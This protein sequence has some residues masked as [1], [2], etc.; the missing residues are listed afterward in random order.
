MVL[1]LK[2]AWPKGNAKLMGLADDTRMGKLKEMIQEHSGISPPCQSILEGYPLKPLLGTDMSLLTDLGVRSGAALTVKVVEAPA[3]PELQQP[4]PTAATNG[5]GT[6]GGGAS[7]IGMLLDMGFAPDLAARA[8]QL[9]GGDAAAAVELCMSGALEGVAAMPAPAP[10]APR[11]LP[12][13]TFVRR[14]I[15]AD[16]SCLFNAVGFCLHRSRRRGGELRAVIA[17]A[18]QAAPDVFTAAILG[19]EAGEY[20][21]WIQD[22][23]KWGGEIELFVLSR[24]FRTEICAVDVQTGIAYTYGEGEGYRERMF[25]LYDGIHY[26]ALSEAFNPTAD[27]SRD[28][29]VFPIGAEADRRLAAAK[30]IAKGLREKKLFV[31]LGGCDLK[32]LVCLEGLRGQAGARA[33]AAATGHQ[34]FGQI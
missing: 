3:A 20:C 22:P 26:D 19:K 30:D 11:D 25:L 32:C 34:N 17:A 10:P 5:G 28:T 2:V 14:V 33:H 1:N 29:A 15:D 27:E 24:H 23:A 21:A 6:D 12:N 16:N 13:P 8:L 31:D 9:A 4:E 18:V 7:A